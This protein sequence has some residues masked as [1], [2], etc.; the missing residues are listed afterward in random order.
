MQTGHDFILPGC[1]GDCPPCEIC[2]E[3]ITP[4]P[5]G[6]FNIECEC[7]PDAD[8][9]KDGVVDFKDFAIVGSQWLDERP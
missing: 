3:T 1:S 7:V 2:Y 8:L 5:D 6:T 4:N 9:N